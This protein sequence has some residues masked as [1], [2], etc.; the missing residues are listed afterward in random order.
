MYWL[1]TTLLALLGLG[2]VLGFLSGFVWQ[3]ARVLSLTVSVIATICL[4]EPATAFLQERLLRGAEPRIVHAVAYVAIF[5]VVYLVLYFAARLIHRWIRA[6]D[7]DMVD[8]LC[9]ALFGAA[10]MA[11]LL[12]VFCLGVANYPHATTK[13]WLSN[14]TLAPAF[15]DGM[16]HL[17]VMIPEEAKDSLRGTLHSLRDLLSRTRSERL[18]DDRPDD[19][20]GWE[21]WR[22]LPEI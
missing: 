4:N 16:E 7:L 19:A 3:I 10:K 2:A 17:V 12:G 1:D 6:T 22:K 18:N 8:R 9:G 21:D 20:D 5:V 11:L 14:S 13:E 15:A